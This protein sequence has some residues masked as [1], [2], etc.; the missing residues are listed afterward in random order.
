MNNRQ[1]KLYDEI[2]IDASKLNGKVSFSEIFRNENPV[3]IEIGSGKGTFLIRQAAEFPDRN[4]LGIE[5]ASKFYRYAVDRLGRWGVKNVKMIRT[6]AAVF[7]PE[8]VTDESISCFHIY[9]PDPWHKRKHNDRR[10][11]CKK[12]L[13]ILHSKLVANGIINIATDHKNYFEWM[14][15]HISQCG[16][17]FEEIDYILPAGAQDGEKAGTN[18][19]RKY[20]KEGRDVYTVAIRKR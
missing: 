12:N 16:E 5:W 19:E 1:L 7:I 17:L 8:N 3:E 10:F 6:D 4:F 18:F 2:A 15:K 13:E 20:L 9:F 11:V 14:L